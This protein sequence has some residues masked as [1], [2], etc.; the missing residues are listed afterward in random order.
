MYQGGI[1]IGQQAITVNDL[2]PSPVQVDLLAKQNVTV[3]VLYADG[4]TPVGAG[5]EVQIYDRTDPDDP[6]RSALQAF[7]VTDVN[8]MADNLI[9][10]PTHLSGGNGYWVRVLGGDGSQV[11]I[12]RDV[13]VAQDVE[14]TPI[15]V[16][17][18]LVRISIA[19]ANR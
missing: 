10:F 11:A 8:G 6:G 14:A 13:L 9:V 12:E 5:Y 15:A 7:G 4:I 2:L 18:N 3:T 16:S 17:T 19:G 1:L